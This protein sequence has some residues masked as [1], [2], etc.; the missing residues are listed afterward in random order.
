MKKHKGITLW[1]DESLSLEV[2]H[3]G[4]QWLNPDKTKLP[5]VRQDEECHIV[6]IKSLSTSLSN[7]DDDS[8]PEVNTSSSKIDCFAFGPPVITSSSKL[9]LNNTE[10][11]KFS[12]KAD[13]M[14]EDGKMKKAK[15]TKKE[16]K[17][18]PLLKK[19]K[20]YSSTSA[21]PSASNS[22][23]PINRYANASFKQIKKS[24]SSKVV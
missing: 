20:K 24:M 1:D 15:E 13:L 16:T 14:S 7:M 4:L 12:T 18:D 17:V 10:K 8:S 5:L 23:G 3:G 2:E 21:L 9:V 11:I 19:N 22:Q 6:P